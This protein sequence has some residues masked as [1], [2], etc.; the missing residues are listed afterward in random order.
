MFGGTMF[1]ALEEYTTLYQYDDGT[2]SRAYTDII[3]LFHLFSPRRLYI[4]KT[5]LFTPQ[6]YTIYSLSFSV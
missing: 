5:D 2:V 4:L 1:R 6:S 3:R